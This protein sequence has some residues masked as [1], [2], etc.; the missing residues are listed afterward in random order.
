MNPPREQ[1]EDSAMSHALIIDDNMVIS[2]AVQKRLESLGFASFD[3][4]WTEA[5]AMAFAERHP[6]DLIVIGDEIE[7]GDAL[8]AAQRIAERLDVPVLM[9]TGD[10]YRAR[11]RLAHNCSLEGPFLLDQI[12]EAVKLAQGGVGAKVSLPVAQ[13][14]PIGASG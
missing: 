8:R 5:Q 13:H 11:K 6:P 4:A 14:G 9:V 3:K 12:E 10:A 2:N 7:G 1:R